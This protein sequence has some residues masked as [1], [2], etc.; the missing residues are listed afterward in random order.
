[1]GSIQVGRAR[2]A[3]HCPAALG[4]AGTAPLLQPNLW[5]QALLCG[6]GWS[7]LEPPAASVGSTKPP[8]Q[9]LRGAGAGHE[10]PAGAPSPAE[11]P[12][13]L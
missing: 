8:S 12:A 5:L 2:P 13:Q 1:M 6:P 7:L 9:L 11:P 3:R 4:H 10:G